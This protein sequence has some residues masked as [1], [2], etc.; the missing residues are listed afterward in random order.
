MSLDIY[1]HN[2][3]SKCEV[4]DA[5][6]PHIDR[7]NYIDIGYSVC[8]SPDCRR[9]MKKKS[10]MN[11]YMFRSHL[12]FNRKLIIK[13]RER[14][15]AK[16]KHLDEIK[17]KEMQESF[18]IQQAIFDENLKLSDNN[19]FL[20]TIPSGDSAQLVITDERRER[21]I[22]H[23]VFIVEEACTYN[24]ASEIEHDEHYHA[25][26]KHLY[27]EKKFDAMPAL[28]AISDRLCCMCKGG[29]CASGKEHAY[30]SVFSVRRYMDENPDVLPEELLEMYINKIPHES[31]I[32][33]CI[34]Q[35]VTGCA[36]TRELR[37]DICNAYYCESLKSY[38]KNVEIKGE[39]SAAIVIQRSSTYWNR[40][41]MGVSNDI[42][43]VKVVD[44][45]HEYDV[46]WRK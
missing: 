7:L 32:N 6:L 29:C 15:I 27:I 22:T 12:D 42:V 9:V 37:S 30:L 20:L 5:L 10:S 8:R 24:N 43:S 36:L 31:V 18:N 16:R 19:T 21:Y 35:T 41:E 17:H 34:N 28:K 25:Y 45:V 40:F 44:E 3:K 33:S 39:L 46:S 11:H 4:C 2:D 23:L 1:T 38:Q 13:Q 26:D 14:S